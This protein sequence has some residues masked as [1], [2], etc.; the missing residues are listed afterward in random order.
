M[1]AL[2]MNMPE[3]IIVPATSMIPSHSLISRLKVP[4]GFFI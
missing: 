4:S 2:T 1:S 3:P